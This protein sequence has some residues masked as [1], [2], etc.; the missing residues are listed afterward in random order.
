[1]ALP[2]FVQVRRRRAAERALS[3]LATNGCQ[4]EG[5]P[6]PR[7]WCEGMVARLRG[8]EPAARG[9]FNRARKEIEKVLRDQP[10]YAEGLC[11]LGMIDAALGEKEAAIQE[12]R[13][14]VEL[15]PI[16]K[17]ALNGA[18]LAE[19]LAV[20]YA[21]VGEKK[22]AIDQ[23]SIIVRRP[24]RVSY[25]ELRWHPYWK[26]LRGEAQFEQIVATLAPK[27]AA[28][29]DVRREEKK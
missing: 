27:E 23:L 15:L 6:F 8:D 20:I 17:D 29:T 7:A 18:R 16:S 10:A 5:I 1:M 9:G 21:T 4:D 13:R 22:R 14:A 3:I 11:V 26:P 25:G 24:G 28:P 12:G 2:C 19:Y